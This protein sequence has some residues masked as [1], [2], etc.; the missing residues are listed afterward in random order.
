LLMTIILPPEKRLSALFLDEQT[1]GCLI[2][3]YYDNSSGKESL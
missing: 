1:L 3:L 2:V